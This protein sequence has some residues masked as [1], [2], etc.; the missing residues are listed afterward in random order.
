MIQVSFIYLFIQLVSLT[1]VITDGKVCVL[2]MR[3]KSINIQ[4]Q[5]KLTM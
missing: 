5:F 2:A 3:L 4:Y 1:I